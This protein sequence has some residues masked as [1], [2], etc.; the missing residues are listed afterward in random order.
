[1][2]YSQA[3][4]Y[5][6]SYYQQEE[7]YETEPNQ[8]IEVQ[9]NTRDKRKKDKKQKDSYDRKHNKWDHFN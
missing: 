2:H 1:M 9:S 5:N 4:D 6:P 3:E 7:D 8:L